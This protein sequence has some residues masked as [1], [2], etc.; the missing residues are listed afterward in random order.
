MVASYP[1]AAGEVVEETDAYETHFTDKQW[2]TAGSGL[3]RP[4]R[5]ALNKRA[6]WAS[7]RVLPAL[8]SVL[9]TCLRTV[10]VGTSAVDAG[11]KLADRSPKNEEEAESS[12]LEMCLDLQEVA[13]I[14]N[15]AWAPLP[16]PQQAIPSILEFLV[17]N[18]QGAGPPQPSNPS[19]LPFLKLAYS[20][21]ASSEPGPSHV[22]ATGIGVRSRA[23]RNEATSETPLGVQQHPQQQV[24]R[25]C[26]DPVEGPSSKFGTPEMSALPA[27]TPLSQV[28]DI[29]EPQPHSSECGWPGPA[30]GETKRFLH[31]ESG[32]PASSPEKKLRAVQEALWKPKND[33]LG[34]K[35]RVPFAVPRTAST[36][37]DQHSSER[38]SGGPED[39]PL[40]TALQAVPAV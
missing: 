5:R 16:S 12:F 40:L 20:P 37:V 3:R 4:S 11:R 6:I 13:G 30:Q 10:G 27:Q 32:S 21:L 36:P 18:L 14:S 8:V 25:F 7:L 23:K 22:E 28:T 35:K 38:A 15:H 17:G 34:L 1:V 39:D 9:V 2:K 19:P 29:A 31:L 33:I 24:S 26:A